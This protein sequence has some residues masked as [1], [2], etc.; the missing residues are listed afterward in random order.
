MP[1]TCAGEEEADEISV[2]WSLLR[3][4]ALVINH[5][6]AHRSLSVPP[7]FPAKKETWKELVKTSLEKNCISPDVMVPEKERNENR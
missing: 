2:P 5:L 4:P 6:S 1:V 3:D 7:T